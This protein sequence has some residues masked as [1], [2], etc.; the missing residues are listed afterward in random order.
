MGL[1]K[2]LEVGLKLVPGLDHVVEKLSFRTDEARAA[3]DHHDF[4]IGVQDSG[5]TPQATR[6]GNIAPAVLAGE[7]LAS[8]HTAAVDEGPGVIRFEYIC[9]V[10][11]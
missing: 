5:L 11:I 9:D 3:R 1:I 2:V 10:K 8:C 4:G 7:V 6:K